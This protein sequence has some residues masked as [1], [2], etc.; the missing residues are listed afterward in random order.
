M[1]S[2]LHDGALVGI[3]RWHLGLLTRIRLL[4]KVVCFTFINLFYKQKHQSTWATIESKNT[5]F[6]SQGHK[7]IKTGL[8]GKLFK[9][10]KSIALYI[11]TSLNVRTDRML[12]IHCIEFRICWKAVLFFDRSIYLFFYFGTVLNIV[13]IC[14]LLFYIVYESYVYSRKSLQGQNEQ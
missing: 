2:F 9:N 12:Y 7:G 11:Q 5:S 1:A 10:T 13:F 4:Y 14:L 6:Y 8:A 3:C